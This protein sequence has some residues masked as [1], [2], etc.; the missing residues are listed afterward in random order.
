VT[1][2][3]QAVYGELLERA[4]RPPH[5]ERSQALRQAF[6]ERC[7]AF[8]ENDESADARESAAWEDALVRGGL[9]RML[10]NELDDAAEREIALALA[11][12]ER[13]VYTFEQMSGCLVARD[14][15]SRA[16]LLI[17]E[18]DHVGRELVQGDLGD[19]SP[20]C[21][22]R[23]IASGAGCLLLPGT[24]FHPIDAKPAIIA[25]LESARQ[26]KL[27]RDSVLDALLRMEHSFRT[28][29]RVKVA[30]AYRADALPR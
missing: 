13:G 12:P 14:L 24:I 26:R 4:S 30:F 21:Q 15:W 22:A 8:D 9:A 25:V 19:D 2:I 29:S 10:A 17:A 5:A 23:I 11:R 3:V 16:E 1:P 27:S 18:H 6:A 20:I 7:G 28:L